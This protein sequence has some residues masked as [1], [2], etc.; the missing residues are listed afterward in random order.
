MKKITFFLFLFFSSPAIFA[1]EASPNNS[2]LFFWQTQGIKLVFILLA[3]LI[4]YK[5]G[6]QKY[7]HQ[8]G[9]EQI[10]RRYLENGVDLVIEGVEHTLGAWRGNFAH[11]LRILK[12][13]R[14]KQK[15]GI[16]L[17]PTEYDG[18]QFRRYK[19]EL[20][21]LTPFYK[22]KTI[23][24]DT[25]NIFY[26]QTCR[27]FAFAE[28][29]ANFCQDDL[30]TAIKVF[31]EKGTYPITAEELCKQYMLKIKEYDDEANKYYTL[32]G[33]LQNIAWII[34]TNA[35][36]LKDIE[37]LKD[38]EDI[39]ACISRLKKTFEDKQKN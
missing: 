18:T 1:A 35:M 2:N 4:A 8:R 12:N 30:C 16:T 28:K 39:K 3:A 25:E 37:K 20:F 5:F 27:L 36:L 11:A 17:N 14:E 32:I 34:E 19:Q 22:L 7:L 9:H 10:T 29:T 6:M 23:I 24:G 21:Y 33:E 38:R 31:V 26:S 13:F 15:L